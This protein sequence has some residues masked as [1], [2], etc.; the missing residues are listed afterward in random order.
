[1]IG[2]TIAHYKITAKL[3]EGGMGVVWRAEDTELGRDVA[4]K[5]MPAETAADPERLDR[6]RREAQ[7]VA[8]LNH[9]NI[10]TLHSVSEHEGMHFLVLELIVGD[11]LDR[12]IPPEGLESEAL[13]ELAI[14]IADA[15]AAAHEKGITH[16][17][18]KPAN[19]MVTREG[20]VKILDFGL[21][22]L[23]E[24]AETGQ[25]TELLTQAGTMLG[26]V[27]YMSPE[28]VQGREADPRS[29]VFSFGILLYEMATG[30]RPF[31]GD[32]PASVISS[33]LR[34][35]PRSVSDIREDLP[36]HLGRI[37]R[38]C[39]EK[40]P[41]RRFQSAR[42]LRIELEELRRELQ[43][44]GAG[45]GAREWRPSPGAAIPN[46]PR[47]TLVRQ[48]GEAGF[49]EVWL[50]VH[51]RTGDQRVFK[52]CFDAARLQALK[53]EITFILL[54]KEELGRREDIAGILDWNFDAAPY[55]IESEYT[56]G[57]DLV[58]WV[59]DQGG[60]ESVPL[61]TRRE[62]VAQVAT[63]LAAAHSVG[64]LHKDLKPESVLI[65]ADPQGRPRARLTD[66][67]VGTPRRN[68]RFGSGVRTDSQVSPEVEPEKPEGAARPHLA[69][70]VLQGGART[71]QADV[72]SVGV[73]LYQMEVG[74]LSRPLPPDWESDIDDEL[75]RADIAWAVDPSPDR[76]LKNVLRI[77]ERLRSLD[78]RRLER[79][80]ETHASEAPRKGPYGRLVLV[81]GILA[82]AILSGLAILSLQDS[83]PPPRL[84]Q[85]ALLPPKGW[86]FAPASP[87]AVSPDGMRVAFVAIARPDNE[88]VPVG[89]NGLWIREL[90]EPESRKLVEV[91]GEA[92]P[93]WAPD[94]RRL[95]FFANRK[96]NKVDISGGPVLPLCDASDGRGGSWND[97][98]VI[99]FQRQ[100]NEGLMKVSAA[101]GACEPATRLNKERSQIAHRWPHFLPDGNHFL[102][103]V[104][105][106]TNPA[107]SEQTGIYIGALGD[108]E[109]R[110]LL[111]T[112]SRAVYAKGHLLYR[113]GTTLM[114]QP[115]DSSSHQF[116]GEPVP[117][118]SGVSGGIISWGGAHFGASREGVIVH[119]RGAEIARTT[120]QWRDRQ[121]DVLATIGEP[122]G[123]WEPRMSHD[124][125]RLAVAVGD[126]VADIWI[127]DLE[128]Q[129]S[130]RLTFDP[131]DDRT[132][133][134][135]PDDRLIA[136]TS[137][138]DAEGEI[139]VRPA[140][141]Q[142]EAEL[143]YTVG[144]QIEL[145]DWSPDGSLLLFNRPSPDDG[146]SHIWGL[147][148][149][150]SEARPIL[151]G[152]WFEDARLSPD[153]KWL[154]YTSNDMGQAQDV[155]VQSFPDA[156]GRWVASGDTN[157]G[158]ASLAVWR[159]DGKELYYLRNG[160]VMAVPVTGDSSLSFGRP[161][162][163]FGV[164][165]PTTGNSD[166][167]ATADGERFLTNELPPA[168]PSEISATL[169][170]NWTRAIER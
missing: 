132:P 8:A 7:S 83:A 148:V 119:M 152:S 45:T 89:S 17:D 71:L 23:A 80:A 84:V 111:R 29:D 166:Y 91:E 5:V 27:P 21:A 28:Q 74:D 20:R 112:D 165:R 138:R 135:S 117:L 151:E 81:A 40:D 99:L 60:L 61:E 123:Y 130:M 4:I 30:T 79:A 39:L 86:D 50:G 162:G 22:K 116:E 62:I 25:A 115:F 136:F 49:G 78:Q 160:L 163:L 48:L 145:T 11:E 32:D 68:R 16:R 101:G 131:K 64:V 153:G 141:G 159:P 3:G 94:S 58:Q 109:M 167:S 104:V 57:G 140:S 10:V 142:G 56:E 149:E 55:F 95:G 134:W 15:L 44:P 2:T 137:S 52:F 18:L 127:Y 75:M 85:S 161:T 46:R 121:G 12:V 118:S 70:E 88:E 150:T 114:A 87:F 66:F 158:F 100:W 107:S 19:V 38:R 156:G 77:A 169:I 53:R 144:R 65:A 37:V 54:L 47:W 106:T 157:S 126:A 170:Q 42:E 14:P 13:F 96:L 69:P 51:E 6:F 120:L 73:L 9:P 133:V 108:G 26:T 92:Y 122:A 110:Q 146:T 41:N 143:L 147:D 154:A 1:M 93:F 97:D 125:K 82:A 128:P 31:D 90:D 33:I 164:S 102:V 129:R 168:D 98:D 72:F 67:G 76:R 24:T 36:N 59:E 35:S 34:D 43:A 139:Y 155:F 105:S 124:G 113:V 103:Y 63:A